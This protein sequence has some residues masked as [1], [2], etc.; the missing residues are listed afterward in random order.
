MTIER[1]LARAGFTLTRDYPVPVERVWD[2]FAEEDQKL[3]LVRRR[4]RLRARRVGVRL[5]RRRTRRRRGDVPRRAGLAVRGH[6]HRHRRAR[7]HR[8]DVRHVARRGAHVDVGGVVRVRADRRGHPVHARRARRLLRPVLGR[9]AEPRGR[10]PGP[11]RG[12]GQLPHVDTRTQ[13]AASNARNMAHHHPREDPLRGQTLPGPRTR[14]SAGSTRG[15]TYPTTIIG[16]S[17]TPDLVHPART[18]RRR[19][20]T[21]PVHLTGAAHR[22]RD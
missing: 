8:H 6:L 1:R 4:R 20:S 3:R 21:R 2:A 16:C 9:R 7:P 14:E 17:P 19:R 12:A 13:R 18:I 22:L 15:G 11:A 10:Q 5:P